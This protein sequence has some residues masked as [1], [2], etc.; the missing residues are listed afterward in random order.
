MIGDY[1]F[2]ETSSRNVEVDGEQMRRVSFRG[3]EQATGDV[4]E[5]LNVDGSFTMPL[6]DYF[7]AGVDGTIPEV[8]REKVMQK[9]SPNEENA[10]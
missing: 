3:E 2:N 5:K 6:M 8:I 9:L 1:N 7:M 10:E 4:H